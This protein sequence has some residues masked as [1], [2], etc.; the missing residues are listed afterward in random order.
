MMKKISMLFIVVAILSP[1]LKAPEAPITITMM[2]GTVLHPY[3]VNDPVLLSFI[4]LESGFK[5]DAV[6][7][8]SGA[9]GVLQILPIMIK[10]V[11][12]ILTQQTYTWEDA[13]N[14][15]KSIEIWYI[16]QQYH[17]PDYSVQKACQIWF[18]TGVQYDGLTWQ[19]YYELL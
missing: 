2:K 12:R 17:N 18:G 5:E 3:N 7:P 4:K 15:I 9:R 1:P 8:V 13:F 11:N 14:A 16:V 19:G 6:N 10:E